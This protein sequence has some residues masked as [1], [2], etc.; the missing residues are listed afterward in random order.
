LL[1]VGQN[2]DEGALEAIPA[3]QLW[4]GECRMFKYRPPV[5]KGNGISG[6]LDIFICPSMKLRPYTTIFF[7]PQNLQARIRLP[8]QV[9]S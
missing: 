8:V 7:T 1:L 5:L 9:L 4:K 2:C 6:Q 3:A